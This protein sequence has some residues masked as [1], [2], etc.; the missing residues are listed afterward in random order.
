MFVI[1]ICISFE[2]PLRPIGSGGGGGGGG[3]GGA[4]A[5]AAAAASSCH[6]S[7][8]STVDIEPQ[9]RVERTDAYFSPTF[10]PPG[11]HGGP[12]VRG[13]RRPHQSV[14]VA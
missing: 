9:P 7:G 2:L 11:P 14:S 8:Y 1:I 4:A 6:P 5:A 3:G 10:P 12:A 13:A